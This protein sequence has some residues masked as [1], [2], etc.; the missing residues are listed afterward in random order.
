MR[1]LLS[2]LN[3]FVYLQKYNLGHG[4]PRRFYICMPR[5]FIIGDGGD[6]TRP[7]PRDGGAKEFRADPSVAGHAQGLC[8]RLIERWKESKVN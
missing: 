5:W 2:E 8:S 3:A 1:K 7:L 6:A 4:M